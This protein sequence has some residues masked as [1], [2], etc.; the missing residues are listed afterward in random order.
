MINGGPYSILHYVEV[1]ELDIFI[2]PHLDLNYTTLA[3]HSEG[4]A[5]RNNRLGLADDLSNIAGIPVIILS[6]TKDPIA[7]SENQLTSRVFY[8]NLGATVEY[9][10]EDFTHTYPTDSDETELVSCADGEKRTVSNCGYD[11]A[12]KVLNHLLPNIPGSNVTEIAPKFEN[13]RK[14]GILRKFN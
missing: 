14:K 5:R 10:E 12:G 2:T 3:S 13:W 11:W 7:P 9:L 6:E 1:S 4:I 8:E